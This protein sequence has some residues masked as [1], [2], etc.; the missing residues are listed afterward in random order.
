M[1]SRSK[2][3]RCPIFGSIGDLKTNVLPTYQDVMKCY[4]WER[5]QLKN[6][7][8]SNATK[9]QSKKEPSFSEI[10]D[11]VTKKV[12]DIWR[13]ASIPTV[14]HTRTIQLLKAFHAKCKNHL[15]SLKRLSE[16]KKTDFLR[17]SEALFDICSCKCSL[18]L[19]SCSRDKKV[20]NE[21]N[22]FLFDQR[23]D[24][25]M[26][27][28]GIDRNRTIVLQKKLS[29]NLKSCSSSKLKQN[30]NDHED[31]TLSSSTS[32]SEESIPS[33]PPVRPSTSQHVAKKT[34]RSFPTVAKTSDR[35]GVSDRAAAAI[36]SAVLHDISSDIEVIDKSKI[37][38]ERKKTRNELLQKQCN[39]NMPAIY[40]D[41]RK[42]K[43]LKIVSK[44]NK[45]YRKVVVEE[46]ISVLKELGS[47]YVGY[48]TPLQGTANSIERAINALLKSNKIC[49]DDILAIGCDGT[50]T[51]TGKFRGIIRL[52]EE[53]LK[54]PLQWIICMLHL[55]ELPLRHLFNKL[56]GKT[57][58]PGS[59]NGPIGKLLE[60]CE[61]KPVVD[62]VA[63]SSQ[64]PVINADDLSTDQKYLYKICTAVIT[65]KCP[66]DL[67]HKSPGK[68]SHARWLTKANRILRLYISTSKPSENLIQLSH[69][70]VK[71]YTP[72][73]FH[74]KAHPTLQSG[75]RNFFQ[76]IK[77]SRYLPSELK[78][79]IDPVIQ[80]NAYFAHPENLLLSLLTD[81]QQH[82]REIAVNKIMNARNSPVT[83]NKPRVFEVPE[84]NFNA[85][86]Y[87]E[88][89][90]WPEI[91]FDP[92]ILR[93]YS[94]EDLMQMTTSNE[95][96]IFNKLPCHTQAVER[97]VKV[98][99]EAAMTLCNKKS[100]E[101]F[102]LA[103]LASRKS[104]PKFD[105]KRD[106]AP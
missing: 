74:V 26:M 96:F 53:R 82:L 38:R 35:Y 66:D 77:N 22:P 37:R 79:V 48:A 55:N 102:I 87:N 99:T 43:T 23:N 101:G 56:D 24:R 64:L 84:I 9:L 14:T 12:E 41:G 7:K 31:H 89:I 40:F 13:K 91:D 80:R 59:Y 98:V 36:A 57:S 11:I 94:N 27:I 34:I 95:H 85:I 29:R 25:K 106:F 70:V 44:G 103:K 69:Y 93:N 2:S 28:T 76:L 32:D 72:V 105:T 33:P 100:R 75:S 62:Y 42:D 68:L 10:A 92:P 78:V 45:K 49:I 58:G 16:D 39:Q 18:Q 90:N 71:V 19:C 46:H 17:K 6:K 21:E 65:G 1:E 60:K 3:Y 15:K 104:M 4:E 8:I 52:F 97:T 47:L 5:Q 88:I 61:T 20:P 73:W 81:E 50:V 86:C 67:A 30:E 54:R 83:G 51:N 63:I